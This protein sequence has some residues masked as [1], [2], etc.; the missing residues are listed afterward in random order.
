MP[1]RDGRE[2]LQEYF[3]RDQLVVILRRPD[4]TNYLLTPT[5]LHFSPQFGETQIWVDVTQDSQAHDQPPSDPPSPRETS[6]C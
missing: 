4:G 3:D 6:P 5:A 2:M 1:R